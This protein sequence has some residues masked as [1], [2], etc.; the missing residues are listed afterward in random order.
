MFSSTRRATPVAFFLAVA[1]T[2]TCVANVLVE[3]AAA[4]T[5][6]PRPGWE[7]TASSYPTNLQPG[8]TGLIVVHVFNVGAASSNGT[9]TVTDTLPPGLTATK[10]GEIKSFL[11]KNPLSSIRKSAIRCGTAWVR[12]S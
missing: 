3:G 4:S 7:L 5:N 2:L 1:L 11:A 10:A 9:V 8:G 12:R 6:A